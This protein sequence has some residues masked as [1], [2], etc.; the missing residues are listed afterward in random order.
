MINPEDQVLDVVYLHSQTVDI[1]RSYEEQTGV[2]ILCEH[3]FSTLS[4]LGEN[5]KIDLDM[6]LHDLNRC[7]GTEP[8]NC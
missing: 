6:L 5:L 8:I 7:T 4:E 2:C 3:L 1:F